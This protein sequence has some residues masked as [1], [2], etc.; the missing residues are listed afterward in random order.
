[1]GRVWRR[2]GVIVVVGRRN[3]SNISPYPAQTHLIIGI[4][5]FLNV[6]PNGK[7]RLRFESSCVRAVMLGSGHTCNSPYLEFT[8]YP[9]HRQSLCSE[10]CF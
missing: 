4:A 5:Q 7:V 10:Q 9:R 3:A 8:L 2:V 6:C 1:M